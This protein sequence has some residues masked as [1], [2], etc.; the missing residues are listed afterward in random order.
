MN[1]L[2]VYEVGPRDGLQNEKTL[3]ETEAKI[4]LIDSLYQAGVRRLEATSFVSP[5]AVPQM[6]D[7]DRI[8]A[9]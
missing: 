4:R 2:T 5:K 1:K 3:I 9:A 7:A 8:T 6:A